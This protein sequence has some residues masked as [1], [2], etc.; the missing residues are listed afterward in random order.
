M[1]ASG[2]AFGEQDLVHLQ[3]AALEV[4]RRARQEQHP[5]PVGFRSYKVYTSLAIR[6]QARDPL[7]AGRA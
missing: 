3:V 6:L 7:G 1:A 4:Y 5:R 2:A